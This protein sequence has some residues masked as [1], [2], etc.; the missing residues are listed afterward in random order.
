MSVLNHE[1]RGIVDVVDQGRAPLG[2]RARK[3]WVLVDIRQPLRP[4]SKN[5]LCDQ[6]L[7]HIALH[8]LALAI[9]RLARVGAA[10]RSISCEVG[11]FAVDGP[12][13]LAGLQWQKP[14]DSFVDDRLEGFWRIRPVEQQAHML[15]PVKALHHV[16]LHIPEHHAEGLVLG[17]VLDALDQHDGVVA[18]TKRLAE[19]RLDAL[20]LV[21]ILLD[22][23]SLVVSE[24]V[25]H[26]VAT[27][28]DPRRE[29]RRRRSGSAATTRCSQQRLGLE[30]LVAFGSDLAEANL[31]V[32]LNPIF[33]FVEVSEQAFCRVVV[34]E[35]P[36]KLT[37]A[38]QRE[39]APPV[40]VAVLVLALVLRAVLRNLTVTVTVGLDFL[41]DSSSQER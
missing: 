13:L 12:R 7:L 27:S 32:E 16:P 33:C 15:R 26:P 22:R 38:P 4:P 10:V 18:M 30:A 3:Q 8:L 25:A 19:R 9:P 29:D 21:C 37:T 11:P 35:L 28:V 20:V 40:L 6:H 31:I 24:A 2:L 34:L 5:D 14:S 41:P 1:D 36:V 23:K 17:A 39:R